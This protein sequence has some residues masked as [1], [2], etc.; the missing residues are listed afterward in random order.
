MINGS[1]WQVSIETLKVRDEITPGQFSFSQLTR[2]DFIS[3][4]Q[5]LVIKEFQRQCG[6]I[7][8]LTRD[9]G[10]RRLML[11]ECGQVA[12]PCNDCRAAG[13]Q[14]WIDLGRPARRGWPSYR[15]WGPT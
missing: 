7:D 6:N 8:R 11:H 13:R 3:L 12:Y 4:A 10:R 9:Y 2:P 5:R 1:V 14:K 15:P